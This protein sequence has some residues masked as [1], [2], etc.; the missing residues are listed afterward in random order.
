M[1]E[2]VW[3]NEDKMHIETGNKCFDKTCQCLFKG[4]AITDTQ[5]SNY[6]RPK[7]E[8]ECNGMVF[9]EGYLRKSDLNGG[10]CLRMPQQYKDAIIKATETEPAILYKIF[11]YRGKMQ[12]VHGWI[13]TKTNNDLIGYYCADHRIKT[14]MV[15]D[16]VVQYLSNPASEKLLDKAV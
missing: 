6:I 16:E 4:N 13:L 3:D 15:M 8:T 1:K 2:I 12:I 9:A 10:I 14:S 5:Y 7:A 11:H